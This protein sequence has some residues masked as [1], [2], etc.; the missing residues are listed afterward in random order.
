MLLIQSYM[1][2]GLTNVKTISMGW[3]DC[4]WQGSSKV[5]FCLTLN[6]YVSATVFDRENVCFC[7]PLWFII[8]HCYLSF[9]CCRWSLE[10]FHHP[11]TG[12]GDITEE[13]QCVSDMH[14]WQHKRCP[15]HNAM[16]KRQG[17]VPSELLVT[18]LLICFSSNPYTFPYTLPLFLSLSIS[19]NHLW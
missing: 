13:W 2:E 12:D 3:K 4:V 1:L 19:L 17:M 9:S 10:T 5:L 15:H 18:C 6:C 14:S 8:I 16:E 11:W 7:F